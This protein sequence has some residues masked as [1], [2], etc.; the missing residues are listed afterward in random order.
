MELNDFNYKYK[1]KLFFKALKLEYGYNI[2]KDLNQ[3][4]LLYKETS[5]KDSKNYLSMA[6]LFEIYRTKDEKFQSYIEKDKNLELIYLFKSFA[7]LPI[8]ILKNNNSPNLFSFDLAYTIA[9]FLDINNLKDT[10]KISL[11]IDKLME[12][13]KY[14]DILSLDD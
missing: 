12:S 1:Y 8:S 10:K 11:Y 5:L 9:T 4:F 6:R 2:Q 14:S 3:A 13:G 7:Y